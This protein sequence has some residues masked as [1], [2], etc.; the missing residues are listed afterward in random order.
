VLVLGKV[1]K[2]LM[3]AP[4]VKPLLSN[5]HVSLEGIVL[6]A[7]ASH[8]SLEPIDGQKIEWRRQQGLTKEV[9]RPERVG[10]EADATSVA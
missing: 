2:T 5:E 10:N 3:N 1:L 6:K 4:Q 8:N 7:W 9:M